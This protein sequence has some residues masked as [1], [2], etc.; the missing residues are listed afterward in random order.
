MPLCRW[1]CSCIP[2]T[3]QTF[4]SSRCLGSGVHSRWPY[5]EAHDRV[6]TTHSS[7][8]QWVYSG[9]L[10]CFHLP[11]LIM[12]ILKKTNTNTLIRSPPGLFLSQITIPLYPC[13]SISWLIVHS[14]LYLKHVYV[15]RVLKHLWIQ[16]IRIVELWKF[17]FYARSWKYLICHIVLHCVSLE[18]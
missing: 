2:R 13:C 17:C 18:Y 7:E 6:T 10:L 11:F 15:L 5:R 12:A 3:I 14:L 4:D 16:T 9:R 1:S 8:Y